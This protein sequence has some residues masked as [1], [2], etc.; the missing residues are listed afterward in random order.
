[1]RI[2]VAGGGLGGLA[3]AV[4]LGGRGHHVL[5]LEPRPHFLGRAAGV[6]L[7]P[8]TLR[9]LGLLGVGEAVRDRSLTIDDLRFM[10][11]VSGDRLARDPLFAWDLN[12]S[13]PLASAHHLD[14]YEPL[15]DA[16]EELDSVSLCPGSEVVDH[17]QHAESV[18]VALADG[19]EITGDA[20]VLTRE[21]P[22]VYS[23]V[24]PTEL[25]ADLWDADAATYWVG[26]DWHVSHYPLPDY[27]YVALSAVHHR[28]TG[29]ILDDR[30]DLEQVL[31]AFPDIG[32]LA[33]NVLTTGRH[34]RLSG[35]RDHAPM[36]RRGDRVARVGG[37]SNRHWP[38]ETADVEQT[39]AD[40]AA[41]AT[42]W[43]ISCGSV[44]RWFAGYA[45]H[46]DEHAARV[47]AMMRF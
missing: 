43:D 42:S 38:L 29:H 32:Y 11:G 41:L 13:T 28:S 4:A 35:A 15:L 33:R 8:R 37:A 14:L 40:V 30:A 12:I 22:A 3:A 24:V 46:R 1:M 31:A 25:I 39:L 21:R 2:L 6:Q 47:A 45:A 44:R 36:I 23:T 9:L 17:Y 20:L 26:E 27:R 18:V 7:T 19:R 5:V 34:W 16:C 10:D